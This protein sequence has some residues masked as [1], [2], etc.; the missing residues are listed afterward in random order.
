MGTI[1]V[2]YYKI[3]K[4][5]TITF[6]SNFIMTFMWLLL[7]NDQGQSPSDKLISFYTTLNH[8]C[9]SEFTCIN[10]PWQKKIFLFS[11]ASHLLCF[12]K[13]ILLLELLKLP[14]T[15][16]NVRVSKVFKWILTKHK[17]SEQISL[18]C[19]NVVLIIKI[20]TRSI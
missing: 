9:T 20:F 11:L 8:S 2:E 17:R 4:G 7:G 1:P 15:R 6:L 3:Q 18:T 13:S 14:S 19:S 16:M 5:Y 10:S 12:L